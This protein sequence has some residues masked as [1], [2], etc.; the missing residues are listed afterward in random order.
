MN[1]S[2]VETEDIIHD[3]NEIEKEFEHDTLI[4]PMS[5]ARSCELYQFKDELQKELNKRQIKQSSY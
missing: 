3:L 2:D 5:Y 4:N 1:L